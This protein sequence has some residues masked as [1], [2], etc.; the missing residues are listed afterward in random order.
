M[1]CWMFGA[2]LSPAWIVAVYLPAG[3]VAVW[4]KGPKLNAHHEI[5]FDREKHKCI[6]NQTS[7]SRKVAEKCPPAL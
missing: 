2:P 1:R 6:I 7:H 3:I 5:T 4:G